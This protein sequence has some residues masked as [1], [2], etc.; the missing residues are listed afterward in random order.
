[1]NKSEIFH[2]EVLNELSTYTTEKVDNYFLKLFMGDDRDKSYWN[3]IYRQYPQYPCYYY[4]YLAC[5]VRVLKA[6][7][8]VEIGADRGASA[9]MMAS[10]GA[11]VYSIDIRNGWEYVKNNKKIVKIVGDSCVIPKGVDLKKT[12]LWLIDGLHT[13]EKVQQELNVYKD[14]IVPGSVVI[15]DDINQHIEL[16]KAIKSDKFASNDIHGNGVG[17]VCV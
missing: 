17:V 12:K 10:E 13:V 15:M 16:W 5:A 2:L 8:V 6:K 11:K 3:E 9:L 7:Q 4:Q 14:Y 1:M